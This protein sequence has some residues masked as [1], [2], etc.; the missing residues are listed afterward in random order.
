[1]AIASE[2]ICMKSADLIKKA[3]L[4][5]G[6]FGQV[7]LCYHKTHGQVVQKTVY[8]GHLPNQKYKQSLM[9]EGRL[10]HKLKHKRI[11]KLLGLI[12][13]DG[14][15]SLVMEF[16]SKGNLL[17]MLARVDVPVSIKG[18]IILDILEGM[19]YLSQNSI[20]HKDLKP[21]NILVDEDFHI[22]I[23][24]LGLATCQSW[25]KLTK[26]ESR[27]KSRLGQRTCG[28]TAGTLS[29]MA[30]EH[31]KSIHALSS[32]KSDV[33][34]FAIV[35]WVVLTRKQPYENALN[36]D[37]MCACV[38]A[39][40]RPD[41]NLIPQST[42]A[43]MVKLM[44][45]C[46]QQNPE[47]RPTFTESYESFQPFYKKSLEK[48]VEKDI[49]QLMAK[50]KGP[51]D[52]LEKMKS[53]SLDSL[54]L[55]GDCPTSLKS[56]EV[57]PVEA[58]IEDLH[59]IASAEQLYQGDAVPVSNLEVKLEQ[60]FNY[61]KYGS[62]DYPDWPDVGPPR[63]SEVGREDRRE[64]PRGARPPLHVSTVQSWTKNDPVPGGT[65]EN[66]PSFSHQSTPSPS[67]VVTPMA[68]PDWSPQYQY[69]PQHEQAQLH[70]IP[71]PE[72]ENPDLS[73]GYKS[74]FLS[75]AKG[76]QIGD[77]NCLYI[78][79]QDFSPSSIQSN[80]SKS[81]YQELL[82]RG[83]SCDGGAYRNAAAEHRDQL[84]AVRPAARPHRCGGGDHRA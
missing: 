14:A 79:C 41:E 83:P 77:N 52:F 63:P 17:A 34:S 51:E 11:V 24:D 20:I 80:G 48:N 18:R 35:V 39:G 60:E 81:M 57:M 46:W 49:P 37:Q 66:F 70:S 15:Y 55:Q 65:L 21:D 59:A 10:L 1:M 30:P 68:S 72:S 5:F 6:G 33:Y 61:H 22:K 78:G 3:P 16:I 50:Y 2:S 69:T 32:E 64:A 28:T 12:M 54:N 23:A 26:E 44:K 56:S 45:N 13:E 67:V 76:V 8:T 7:Y 9:E 40:D 42:P 75:N 27:N 43:E 36:E 4:D 58:S 71:I 31:L 29:Y 25:S 84:E 82:L 38:R 73:T 74:V 47:Q 53:L 62:Y 19:V